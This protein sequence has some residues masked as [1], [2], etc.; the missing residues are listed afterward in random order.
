M[1][2][3]FGCGEGCGPPKKRAAE[4]V[5]ETARDLFYKHGIRAVGV[6]E[7][8]SQAGVT[9]PSLYRSYASKDEL[10]TSCLRQHD[11]ESR[12]RWDAALAKSPGNPRAQ[13]RNLFL[14]FAE[15]AANEGFRGCPVSNTVVEFPDPDHPAHK[16]ATGM[17][18][19]FRQRMFGLVSQLDVDR[20][21]ELT[22]ALILLLEGTATTCQQFH[23]GGPRAAFI[24]AAEALIDSYLH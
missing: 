7:I 3:V 22:D 16:L 9:K 8:V 4:K 15:L 17:K 13:L 12:V 2:L 10:I 6:D 18:A 14:A 19:E 11:A 21:E 24:P 1:D 5:S 23:K 20:P